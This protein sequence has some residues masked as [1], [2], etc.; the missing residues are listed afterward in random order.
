[1]ESA[2]ETKVLSTVRIVSQE[3]LEDKGVDLSLNDDD[4][5]Q[6]LHDVLEERAK[7]TKRRDPGQNAADA[8]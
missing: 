3:I 6:Y 4:A 2:L 7:L 1:M 8:T 5:K